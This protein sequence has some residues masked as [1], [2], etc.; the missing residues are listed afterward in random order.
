[1][2]T[3]EAAGLSG[4]RPRWPRLFDNPKTYLALLLI[5]LALMPA[6]DATV[7]YFYH[8]ETYNNHQEQ[9]AEAVELTGGREFIQ[10][11]H[12]KGLFTRL[13]VCLDTYGRENSGE[14]EISIIKDGRQIHSRTVPM[15]S[16]KAGR[17]M[18][19]LGGWWKPWHVQGPV[20]LKIRAKGGPAGGSA[21]LVL[22]NGLYF[23]RLTHGGQT[24]QKNL[25]LGLPPL[26]L[27]RLGLFIALVILVQLAAVSIFS[28]RPNERRLFWLAFFIVLLGLCHKFPPLTFMAE[29]YHE[30]GS[31]FFKLTA[32]YPWRESVFIKDFTYWPLFQRLISKF[33]MKVIGRDEWAF[34][35]MYMTMT[36]LLAAACS[37]F[38]LKAYGRYMKKEFRFIC[39]VFLGLTPMVSSLG[40]MFF[41][42]AV[43][44][45]LLYLFMIVMLD[46]NALSRRVYMLVLFSCVVCISKAHY[47]LLMPFA[48]ACLAYC[49]IRRTNRRLGL[50]AAV[51]L[52]QN[53]YVGQWLPKAAGG[54]RLVNLFT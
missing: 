33:Y 8:K 53:Y 14:M 51:L 4:K 29:P 32:E 42:N 19:E 39:C 46:L 16:L 9:V 49:L 31:N 1:M 18:L 41:I 20:E 12:I 22:S 13:A 52:F 15:S 26:S 50:F 54:W 23:G 11:I 21:G 48:L 47:I 44:F 24:L 35:F 6:L 37:M 3:T 27:I 30:A 38:C 45:G 7:R 43:Y 28:P 40:A 2:N 25:F 34:L 5:A 36:A 10:K 17:H